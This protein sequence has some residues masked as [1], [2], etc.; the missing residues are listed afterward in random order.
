MKK[1]YAICLLALAAVV[2]DVVF[3]HTGSVRAQSDQTV[4]VERLL[5]NSDTRRVDA[6]ISGRVLGFH[7]VDTPGGPQCFVASGFA[8]GNSR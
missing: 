3:F 1:V 5:F 8:P 7:C 4:R 6:P 2:F